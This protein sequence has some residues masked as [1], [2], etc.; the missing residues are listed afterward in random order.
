MATSRFS[1]PVITL[2]LIVVSVVMLFPFYWMV[3]SSFKPMGQ[4][5]TVPLELF[6][7][8]F[9][10]SSYEKLLSNTPFIRW[11]FNSLIVTALYTGLAIFFS[12]LAGFGFSKYDFKGRNVLL[13][14]VL[15]S[16][17]IPLH[18]V[19]IPLFMLLVRIEWV[20]TYQGVVIP[21]SASAFGIFYMTQYMR[22][23]PSELL[24]A[25]R[26]DGCSELGLY[27]RIMLPLLKPAIG[28][29]TI[30]FSMVSWNWFLWP[31]V[32]M[33]DQS[34]FTL[35]V[36][37]AT[38]ISDYRQRYDELMAGS[39]LSSIPIILLFLFMQRSF[40]SGLTAGAVKQ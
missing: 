38:L 14:I 31:L 34:M 27:G 23:I 30:Y 15:A 28:V 6:P 29:L 7:T 33:R 37:L 3:T 8:T 21:F 11:Y 39:V 32:V 9:T 24:D 13:V 35:N 25:G 26:I 10:L 12:T 18:S 4:L 40:I 2:I 16:M 1:V 20:N 5:F 17:M 19:A 22:S 36:G